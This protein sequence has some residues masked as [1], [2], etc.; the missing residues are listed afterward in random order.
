[1]FEARL[2]AARARQKTTYNRY[3][4]TIESAGK[5]AI[6]LARSANDK[7][8]DTKVNDNK[9]L[10][11]KLKEPDEW[12]GHTGKTYRRHL[13]AFTA[14]KSIS[15]IP[16]KLLDYRVAMSDP[17]D[18][19]G[20]VKEVRLSELLLTHADLAN[21]LDDILERELLEY[22]LNTVH[23]QSVLRY[24]THHYNHE[25]VTAFTGDLLSLVDHS[26]PT[27]GMIDAAMK[28]IKK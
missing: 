22:A 2:I 4:A 19:K 10:K 25:V 14:C 13:M 17:T 12:K 3:A 6:V 9:L 11:R 8:V 23:V 18:A 26:I 24:L 21:N 7:E 20:R 1:M 16:W 28:R 5:T 27:H 15:V